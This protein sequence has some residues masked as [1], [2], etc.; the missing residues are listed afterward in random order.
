MTDIGNGIACE[1]RLDVKVEAK[2]IYEM[3]IAPTDATIAGTGITFTVNYTD[4][5]ITVDVPD[6]RIYIIRDPSAGANNVGVVGIY[7]QNGSLVK[8]YAPYDFF[9]ALFDNIV[10]TF[11]DRSKPD[12]VVTDAAT[13]AESYIMSTFDTQK[14]ADGGQSIFISGK[15]TMRTIIR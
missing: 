15:A 3:N 9:M 1:L 7:D 6:G 8:T 10:L 11:T 5:T 13:S 12:I 2:R 14:V 4:K